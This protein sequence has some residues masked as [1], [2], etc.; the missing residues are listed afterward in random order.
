VTIWTRRFDSRVSRAGG[1]HHDVELTNLRRALQHLHRLRVVGDLKLQASR[2]TNE[3]A[4]IAPSRAARRTGSE[5]TTP[6]PRYWRALNPSTP[7]SKV[8]AAFG[9]PLSY[10]N[11]SSGASAM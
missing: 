8:A 9:P 5:V 4:A 1:A 6:M 10:S 11:F 7:A 2:E 3:A